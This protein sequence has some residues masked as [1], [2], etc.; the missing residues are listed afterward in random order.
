MPPKKKFTKED[1]LRA[2]FNIVKKHGL[3]KLTARYVAVKL[4]SS[5]VPVYSNFSSMTALRKEVLKMAKDLMFEYSTKPYTDR[6]FLNI[7]TGIV[8][9]ARD[10]KNLF[11]ALFLE[12]AVMKEIVDDYLNSIKVE[13][14]KDLRFKDMTGDERN[15]LLIKMWIFT[16]GLASLVCVGLVKDSRESIIN[17]LLGVGSAV[18]GA[19]LQESR[20]NREKK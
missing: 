12:K 18:I 19:A 3:D 16:H 1:I 9:F 7:G 17:E 2:A 20:L 15:G 10:N 8:L 6:T 4:K 13:M 14:K 11:R 5:Q